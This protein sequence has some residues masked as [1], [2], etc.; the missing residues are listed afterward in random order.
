MVMLDEAKMQTEWED[1]TADGQ[2]VGRDGGVAIGYVDIMHSGRM[3]C[4]KD[5]T[6]LSITEYNVF[7]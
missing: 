7:H 4:C 2:G 1:K 3:L 5:N 6:E